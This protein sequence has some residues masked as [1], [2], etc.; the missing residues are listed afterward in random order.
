MRLDAENDDGIYVRPGTEHILDLGG[1][2]GEEG[3][4]ICANKQWTEDAQINLG[5]DRAQCS[6]ILGCGNHF[7]AE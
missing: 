6:S 7:A 5:V 4:V 1:D 2:H 3:L